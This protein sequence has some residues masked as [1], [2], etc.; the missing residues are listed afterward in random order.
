MQ[1]AEF[2]PFSPVAHAE[3][4]AEID[5][6]ADE[7]YQ[8]RDRDQI[9]RAD[10]KQAERDGGCEPG[11]DRHH[12]RK[13]DAAPAQREP[14][15]QPHSGKRYRGVEPGM[16]GQR[17]KTVIIDRHQPRQ[18]D[19]RLVL[20][21]ELE[22]ARSLFD[23]VACGTAGFKGAIVEDRV[24]FD[25]A[26]KLAGLHGMSARQRLPGKSR[27]AA[28]ERRLRRVGGHLHRPR[29]RIE[30]QIPGSHTSEAV[31]QGFE[32]A[33]QARIRR[34]GGDQ[35]AALGET[36]GHLF[37]LAGREIEQPVMFE[38]GA[39]L[40]L[41][42]RADQVL[43][44]GQCCCELGGG[45]F[46]ILGC[47]RFDD[48]DDARLGNGPHIVERALRPGQVWRKQRRGVCIDREMPYGIDAAGPCKD[49]CCNQNP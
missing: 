47:R 27:R 7:Q 9:E 40:R 2:V 39:A 34:E 42:N 10:Q 14:Q 4:D 18:S 13:N 19:T 6:K 8:E 33:M 21:A 12:H 48:D 32:S 30:R 1:I 15:D 26:A 37:H 3:L 38:E 45:L 41:P 31:R 28:G 16:L 46:D 23:R 24:D 20:R 22:L 49:C 29:H 44:G 36:L 11:R 35:R 43:M 17:R 5:A 25:K